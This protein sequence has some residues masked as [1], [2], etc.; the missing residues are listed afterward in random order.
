MRAL[1]A[2]PATVL[3]LL[4]TL[5]TL[6]STAAAQRTDQRVTHSTLTAA[7]ERLVSAEVALGTLD[8][9]EKHSPAPTTAADS[10]HARWLSGVRARLAAQTAALRREMSHV[11]RANGDSTSASRLVGEMASLSAQFGALQRAILRESGKYQTL[12]NASKARHDVAM[13]AIRNMKA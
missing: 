2:A 3:G 5:A 1:S 12:S 11:Q 9:L 10:A 4:L 13:N 8:S 6:T 7:R